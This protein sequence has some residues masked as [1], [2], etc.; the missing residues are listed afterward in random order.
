LKL[1]EVGAKLY[2]GKSYTGSEGMAF[3]GLMIRSELDWNKTWA[4]TE[5]I[6]L[7]HQFTPSQ[8]LEVQPDSRAEIDKAA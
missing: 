8:I 6:D 7:S 2:A 1:V 4:R 3:K 5:L